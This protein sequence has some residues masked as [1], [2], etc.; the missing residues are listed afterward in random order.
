MN[1]SNGKCISQ[2]T[3]CIPTYKSD[4]L[5]PKPIGPSAYIIILIN[6][7]L[8]YRRLVASF[9]KILNWFSILIWVP[10]RPFDSCSLKQNF[11]S[12]KYA[13][14]YEEYTV[15]IYFRPLPG[16]RYHRPYNS[17]KKNKHLAY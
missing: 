11:E 4:R 7:T 1:H 2:H 12:M 9:E 15:G 8:I 10:R 3:Y 6:Y 16:V 13:I 14:H 5:L 17:C